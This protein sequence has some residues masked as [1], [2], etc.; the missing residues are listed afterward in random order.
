MQFFFLRRMRY[1]RPRFSLLHF[2]KYIR[3]EIDAVTGESLITSRAVDERPGLAWVTPRERGFWRR[4]S[5]RYWKW[6]LA[7]SFPRVIIR[8]D[9]RWRWNGSKRRLSSR[10]LKKETPERQSKTDIK[11]IFLQTQRA[12]K[13]RREI[14]WRGYARYCVIKEF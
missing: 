11:E 13:S 1:I 3:I 6:K 12:R 5:A 7:H 14:W 9:R 8:V 4:L 10:D 2:N